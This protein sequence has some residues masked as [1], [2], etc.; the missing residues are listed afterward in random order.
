MK[1][2]PDSP[3]VELIK[4]FLDNYKDKDKDKD[5]NAKIWKKVGN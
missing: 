1:E 3:T 5:I 4:Y 2:Y